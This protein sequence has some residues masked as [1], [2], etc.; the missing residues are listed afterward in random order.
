M[1]E[2]LFS[3]PLS[4]TQKAELKKIRSSYERMEQF[5]ASNSFSE[6]EFQRLSDFSFDINVT[7]LRKVQAQSRKRLAVF[8]NSG[9]RNEAL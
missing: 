4:K 8:E 9:Y 7:E 6:E 1:I 5:T 3:M 2:Q